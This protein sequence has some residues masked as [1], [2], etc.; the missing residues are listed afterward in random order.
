ML[1]KIKKYQAQILLGLIFLLALVLRFWWFPENVYFGYDQARDAFVSQEIYQNKDFKIIGPSAGKEGLYH[2]PLYWYLIGP[3]YLL[4]QGNP[5]GPLAFISL[6]NALGVFLVYYFGKNLF[7][8]KTGLFAAVL[9]SFF[10]SQTQYSLYFANPAPAVLSISAYFLGWTLLLLKNKPWA[11]ILIGLGLGLSIQFEFFLVYLGICCLIFPILFF[12]SF[13]E[14]LNLKF[15]ALGILSFIAS[16][17][18]FILAELKYG[19]RTTKTLFSVLTFVSSPGSGEKMATSTF[20]GRLGEE[21]RFGLVGLNSSYNNYL[22]LGFIAL[23]VYVFLKKKE[24]RKKLLIPFV[25]IASNLFVDFFGSPQLYYVNIG[26]SVSIILFIAYLFSKIWTFKKAVAILAVVFLAFN[27]LSFAQKYNPKGPINTLYVQEGMLLQD[28][29][30][31]VDLIYQDA[32]GKEFT[33]NA[34]IMPYNI[35]TTWAYLF[36]WYGRQKYGYVPYWGGEDVPGYAGQ[37]PLSSSS[38]LVRYAIYEPERGI[39]EELKK[40]FVDSENG[41]GKPVARE[42]IGQ[43]VIEKRV[44][45]SE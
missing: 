10:F 43:F 20:L 23:F 18:S 34:L 33:V 37:M 25:W 30:K 39:P 19:F 11:W 28:E 17:S 29:K 32:G 9:Y 1:K 16:V 3:V 41:F 22:A 15:L 4:F 31:I 38:S 14:N 40:I 27:N 12:R 35:K 8:Q 6:L 7:D 5:A 24:D 36:N 21:V 45:T 26:V 44:P 13:K 42:E 2:G